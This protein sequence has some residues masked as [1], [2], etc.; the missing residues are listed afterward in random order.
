MNLREMTDADV[1]H[2]AGSLVCSCGCERRMHNGY[3]GFCKNCCR[4]RGFTPMSDADRLLHEEERDRTISL[5]LSRPPSSP[6]VI[7][8]GPTWGKKVWREP[9]Q[10]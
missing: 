1:F 4:C 8:G 9:L 10:P 3:D 2:A 6:L 7:Q 5:A